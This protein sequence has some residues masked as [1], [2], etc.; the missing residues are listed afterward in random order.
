MKIPRATKST[1][2]PTV[3]PAPQSTPKVS[4]PRP[5]QSTQDAPKKSVPT[6][7]PINRSPN[8]AS[9]SGGLDD[10]FGFGNQEGRMKIPR[11]NPAGAD[12]KKSRPIFDKNPVQKPDDGNASS[13]K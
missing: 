9:G 5:V 11:S 1:S 7:K 10:L 13:K 8:A 6:T 3:H 2:T 4:V 12:A